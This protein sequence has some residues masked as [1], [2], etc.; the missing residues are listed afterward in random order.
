MNT[1]LKVIRNCLAAGLSMVAIVAW[2]NVASPEEMA[3]KKSWV[4]RNFQA[5]HHGAPKAGLPAATNHAPFSFTYGGRSSSELLGSWR[6]KDKQR[7]LDAN[8]T[9]QT[10][11]WTDPNSG[12][13]VRC[14]A[15]DYRDFPTVEWTLYFKNTGGKDTE[16]LSDIRA[17]DTLIRRQP[18][19]EFMLRHWLGSQAS[20]EDYQPQE[21][22]LGPD[23]SLSLAPSGGKNEIMALTGGR[24]TC[25]NWPYFNIDWGGEGMLVAVGWP[26]RWAATFARDGGAKLHV[27]AG[28]EMTHFKLH[29]GE[30]VRSPLIAMQFW[31]GGD[32]IRAQ[33]VWRRWMLAHNVPRENGVL[34]KPFTATCVDGAFPGM[35]SNAKGEIQ[36]M[37][38]YV[39]HGTPIDYW[40]IDAGWYSAKG[41]WENIG[42]WEPDPKRFPKGVREVFDHA[43]KLGMKTVLWHEPERVR[44][45]TWLWEKHPEWLLGTDPNYRLLNLGNPETL[46]WAI[47]HFDREITEQGVDLY[48]QDFNFDP[49]S[50][51]RGGESEDRQGINENKDV[52][53]YLAF[54]D[55]LRQ[56]HPGMII[57]SCASGGR[58]NDLE[59]MRRAV[60]L[61][62]SDY[63]FEPVGTQGHNYGISSWI[64]FH[65]TGVGPSTPYVMRSHYRPCYGYG[66]EDMHHPSDY[67]ICIRM[68]REWRQIA[69]DL[70][71]DYYPLTSYSLGEDT[72]VAWQY[73]QPEKGQ[74]VVQAFRHSKSPHET[75]RF[76]LRGLDPAA[77]YELRNFD[78]KGTATASGRELMDPGLL[79]TLTNTPDSAVISY[80]RVGQAK[81]E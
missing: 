15:V 64:P 51:W 29:P 49:L 74:G 16:I 72:W 19:G 57:D 22:T 32:W 8:R 11:T 67:E 68:A 52:T 36:W 1:R 60:P 37:D 26:G 35:L 46:Q 50:C 23:A 73:D 25:G 58:R 33:N 20:K 63:R 71:G 45:G 53:G 47:N 55:G 14:V 5:P 13:A 81:K 61:L 44:P 34:P 40:W 7:Q 77:T 17:I 27:R 54:W 42:T 65:G 3:Q 69:D 38:E 10:I 41:D 6:R 80:K 75:A 48:R 21:T 18:Q 78:V 12:L 9:E 43:H 2:G 39:K 66:G 56:R 59:T 4:A 79:L 30:E 28:Q 70:L 24:G 76:K 31:H 62:A